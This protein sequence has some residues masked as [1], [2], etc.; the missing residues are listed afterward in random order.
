MVENL[1]EYTRLKNF[2]NILLKTI[3]A[4]FDDNLSEQEIIKLLK[5]AEEELIKVNIIKI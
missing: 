5:N 2:R 3:L 4:S 1:K